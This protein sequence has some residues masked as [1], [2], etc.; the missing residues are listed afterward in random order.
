MSTQDVLKIRYVGAVDVGLLVRA[1]DPRTA[2]HAAETLVAR[3]DVATA[4]VA[5][6]SWPRRLNWALERWRHRDKRFMVHLY[7]SIEAWSPLDKSHLL[8][9][10]SGLLSGEWRQQLLRAGVLILSTKNSKVYEL[11]PE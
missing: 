7:I 1:K 5:A 2:E 11:E 9:W 4:R 3:S 10:I 8:R 6:A